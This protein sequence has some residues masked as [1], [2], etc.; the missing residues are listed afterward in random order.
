[1]SYSNFVRRVCICGREFGTDCNEW[2]C[3]QECEDHAREEAE[4]REAADAA[5]DACRPR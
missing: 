5:L 2:F 3:S 4:E 1:M